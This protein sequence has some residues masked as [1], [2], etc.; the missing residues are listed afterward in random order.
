MKIYTQQ[1]HRIQ[2]AEAK[3]ERH[4]VLPDG[5]AHDCDLHQVVLLKK[6]DLTNGN[7]EVTVNDSREKMMRSLIMEIT[8]R[9]RPTRPTMC[10]K[11]PFSIASSS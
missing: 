4:Q 2:E 5:A 9:M 10:S 7:V 1:G 3:C 8:H 11:F 6:R